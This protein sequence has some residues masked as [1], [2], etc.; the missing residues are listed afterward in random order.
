MKKHHVVLTEEEFHELQAMK[1]VPLQ[2]LPIDQAEKSLIM[3]EVMKRFGGGTQQQQQ[4][5]QPQQQQQTHRIPVVVC[6][7]VDDAVVCHV[8]RAG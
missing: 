6:G 7:M 2:E 3:E 1:M 5:Q 4:Q 8:V